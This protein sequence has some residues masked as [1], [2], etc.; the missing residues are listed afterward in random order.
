MNLKELKVWAEENYAKDNVQLM[1]NGVLS[2]K[3]SK[4]KPH[5]KS[6][7]EKSA[8]IIS[9]T[10]KNNT[11]MNN[12]ENDIKLLGQWGLSRTVKEPISELV[13]SAKRDK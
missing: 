12:I 4:I 1:A 11:M 13:G 7:I 8:W 10:E 6:I 3:I 5:L 2:N 9:T